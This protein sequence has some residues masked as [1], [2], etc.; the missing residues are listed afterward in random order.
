MERLVYFRGFLCGSVLINIVQFSMLN[1]SLIELDGLFVSGDHKQ[2]RPNTAVYQLARHF[3]FDVSLFERML[4]NR[5]QC[6]TLMVQHRMS[7]VIASLIVPT[8]YDQL[9]NHPSVL[10][11]PLIDGIPQRLFFLTHSHREKQV[12]RAISIY[13]NLK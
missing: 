1:S 7:P 12:S 3:N 8:V 9:D 4:R 2:L 13:F 6:E 11:F 10:H 5:G